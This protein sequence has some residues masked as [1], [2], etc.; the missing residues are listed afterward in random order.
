MEKNERR[1]WWSRHSGGVIVVGAVVLIVLVWY[2]AAEFLLWRYGDLQTVAL[3]GN[4]YGAVGALFVG[5]SLSGLV[6]SLYVQRKDFQQSLRQLIQQ[7]EAQ[8]LSAEALSEQN[9]AMRLNARVLVATTL[10]Q[11]AFKRYIDTG[12]DEHD[13]RGMFAFEKSELKALKAEIDSIW[14]ELRTKVPAGPQPRSGA[15]E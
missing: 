2:G 15:N 14:D 12:F 7:S 13:L 5:L 9:A 8:R 6:Y 11:A 4:G 1:R 10:L 3:V